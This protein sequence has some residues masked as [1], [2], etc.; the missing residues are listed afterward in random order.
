MMRPNSWSNYSLAK[1]SLQ[2]VGD[3][4]GTPEKVRYWELG[5]K[6]GSP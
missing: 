3:G 1:V 5:T 4:I 2:F 6:Y